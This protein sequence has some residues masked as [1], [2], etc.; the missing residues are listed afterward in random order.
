MESAVRRRAPFGPLPH[1]PSV[2]R[3]SQFPV[4]VALR[5]LPRLR[6]QRRTGRLGDVRPDGQRAVGTAGDQRDV[7]LLQSELQSARLGQT[8]P[9]NVKDA[10]PGQV[11]QVTPN[12]SIADALNKY[13]HYILQ[14]ADAKSPWQYYNL[15]DVQWARNPKVISDLPAPLSPP[16]PNG[17]P[18]V[19]ADN[20]DMLNPVLETFLQEP[21]PPP[22][23]PPAPGNSARAAINMQRRRRSAS[24]NRLTRRATAS[25]SEAPRRCRRMRVS[26]TTR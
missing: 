14:Q 3:R 17:T 12:A 21:Y 16:L 15:I 20:K 8:V 26:A 19:P 13:M 1:R 22:P 7:Q 25:C 24:S 11:L 6:R 23:G 18:N 10:D 2:A 5:R 9:V 4:T